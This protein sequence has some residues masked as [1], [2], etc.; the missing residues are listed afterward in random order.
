[1]QTHKKKRLLLRL[2]GGF[3]TFTSGLILICLLNWGTSVYIPLNIALGL[4]GITLCMVG[5]RLFL[6]AT[7]DDE[8]IQVTGSELGTIQLNSCCLVAYESET[9]DGKKQFRLASSRPLSP[10]REAALIRYLAVEGFLISLWP[11]MK[12]RIED[13]AG[14]AFLGY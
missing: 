10:E 9:A 13:E 8:P 4:A 14:W 7:A 2:C 5:M 12:E 3:L 11:E 1:M 6:I